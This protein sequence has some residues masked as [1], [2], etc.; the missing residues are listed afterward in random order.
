[1]HWLQGKKTVIGSLLSGVVLIAWSL[2]LLDQEAALGALGVLAAFTGVSLRLA[3][4][5][6]R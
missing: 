2:K 6:S 1:M 4:K 3:V 5:K